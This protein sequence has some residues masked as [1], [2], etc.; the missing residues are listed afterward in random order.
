M[1]ASWPFGSRARTRQLI[2]TAGVVG[3]AVASLGV[4]SAAAA[5]PTTPVPKACPATSLVNAELKEKNKAVVTTTTAT[6]GRICTYAGNA[7]VPTTIRFGE[8]TPAA[9]AASQKAASKGVAVVSVK[10]LGT[11]AWVVKRGNGLSVLAGTLDITI[12]APS[13]TPAELEALARKLL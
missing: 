12:S 13:T 7:V 1:S 3:V 8:T 9:F 10:G 4:S 2:V 6:G 11:A 5:A